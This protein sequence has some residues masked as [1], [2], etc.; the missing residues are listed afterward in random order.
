MH[1]CERKMTCTSRCY[2]I[3]GVLVIGGIFAEIG[4]L[5][6]CCLALSLGGRLMGEAERDLLDW[7][8]GD[9]QY[10]SRCR[11]AEDEGADR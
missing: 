10:I 9:I 5:A 8:I 2:R 4:V 11:E 6:N 7:K 3:A 1:L